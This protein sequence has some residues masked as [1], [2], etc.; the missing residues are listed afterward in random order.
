MGQG[1][2]NVVSEGR[3]CTHVLIYGMT[4]LSSCAMFGIYIITNIPHSKEK[5]NPKKVLGGGGSQRFI[6]IGNQSVF[7][8]ALGPCSV[9]IL[10]EKGRG[11]AK[12]ER[13]LFQVNYTNQM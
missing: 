9:H 6:A 13:V 2:E 3:T 7:C 1:V 10:P 4:W 11:G 12:I 5:Q 8:F